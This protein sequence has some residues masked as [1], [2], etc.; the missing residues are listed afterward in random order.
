MHIERLHLSGFR[1]FGPQESTIALKRDLTAFIGVN[2]AGKTAVLLAL[3]RLF[4]V[5][6]DQRRLRR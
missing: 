3:A 1:C 6:S 4:G 2:G 5:T